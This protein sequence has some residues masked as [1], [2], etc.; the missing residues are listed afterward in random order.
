[1][2]PTK[3]FLCSLFFFSCLLSMA[4]SNYV[5]EL[6]FFHIPANPKNDGR[7]TN[8]SLTMG[9]MPSN[10][11]IEERPLPQIF[12]SPLEEVTYTSIF[13]TLWQKISG[14][15]QMSLNLAKTIS[16][17]Y[18]TRGACISRDAISSFIQSSAWAIT[19]LWSWILLRTISWVLQV[20]IN[21]TML[22]VSL[23]LLGTCTVFMAKLLHLLFGSFSVW[24]VVPVWKT[25]RF[26]TSSSSKKGSKVKKEKMV[27]GFGSYDMMMSPPKNC[28]LEVMHDNGQHSGYASC[29]LLASGELALLTSFHLYEDADSVYS[30]KTG[31]KIPIGEFK[32]IAGSQNGDLLLLAGPPNWTGL[33]GCKSV[34]LITMKSLAG[35]DARIFYLKN[36]E[37]YSG[38]AKIQGRNERHG[39]N[40]VD[41]LSNTE[42]GFSGTPYFI[43]NKIA[44]VHT[45]G[46]AEDNV[47]LMAAIPSLDGI[48]ASRY[49]FETTAP[50]GKIFDQDLWEELLEEFSMQ[51]ARTIMKRKAY[52][53]ESHPGSF[54]QNSFKRGAR[55]RPRNNRKRLHPHE[56][57][58][59]WRAY[60]ENNGP[61][62][63]EN[64]HQSYRGGSR[65]TYCP[66]IQDKQA[67]PFSAQEQR[68]TWRRDQANSFRQFFETQYNWEIPTTSKEVPGFEACGKIPQFY[69]PKQ[70]Q[71]GR[72]GEKVVAE[73]PEMGRKVSG[74]GWPEFGSEAELKSLQLQTARWLKRAESAK[75]PSAEA[76]E[77]VVR[78]T[79]EA[80]KNVKSHCPAVTRLGQLS[81]DQFQKSFQAAVH[82]LELDAGVGVP[83]IAYGLPTHKGWVEN[84]ERELLPVLAQLTFDRLKRMSEVN[85]EKLTAEELVQLGLCDP[86]RLFVKGEPHKQSKLDEGRYRLIMSVSLVDQLVARVLFQEQNKLEINLWRAIPSKPGMGLSTDAQVAD[87]LDSLAQ[88]VQVPVEDLVYN[89]EKHVVPTDCSGFDWSVTDWLLEDE[90]EVRNR[91]TQGNNALTRRLRGCWLKCI[92]NS[93]L[94]LSNGILYAQ[95]V[96]GV[97]KSGSY[98]TSS[99]NSRIRFMCSKYAGASWA[100]AM[101]DDALES[102]DTD[103]DVY[104]EI[105][106]KVEVSGQLEFCS[107]IFEKPD[108]AVPVNVGKMLYKLIYGYNPECGSIQ[109]LR[110]YIDACTSV[111]NELRHDPELVALLH[112]WL[113]NPV[114][115]QK[116]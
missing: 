61:I 96:P 41:V 72:W 36:G 105:G 110:N 46:C 114:L 4:A 52:I 3:L 40:F 80:Y 89:W 14:D 86:I 54:S 15:M 63:R 62:G 1:M 75:I 53:P 100:I 29:V 88:H 85:F 91:L 94:A 22:L 98:N 19:W 64:K 48:T 66:E 11:V 78:Q 16:K 56:Q 107:H 30:R 115:P 79:V 2:A 49:V 34:Q 28:I 17:D 37:W 18:L 12:K 104:K 23:G 109:V 33:L 27:K 87:F 47:N 71:Q 39:F 31:N 59:R 113:L 50:K 84:K 51:E 74:F 106:L 70:K 8:S 20:L 93:V 111:L 55:R 26:L 73:H 95:R 68:A 65:K 99:S 60:G 32:P 97:Q 108:L 92:S 82:S 24:I 9:Y 101:G 38:V 35:G 5:E 42:P 6:S 43:G 77:R 81:W 112:Q 83:Y 90:M 58:R 69:H 21:N 116:I 76:R 13:K 25:L 57:A 103:L 102:V 7:L 67:P 45:G 10:W 44:G